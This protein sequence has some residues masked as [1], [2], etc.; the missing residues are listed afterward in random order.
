MIGACVGRGG[1]LL[2]DEAQYL[3]KRNPRGKDT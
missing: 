3:V 1:L 2:V